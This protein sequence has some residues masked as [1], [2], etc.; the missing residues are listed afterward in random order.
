M[1]RLPSVTA[2]QVVAALKRAGYVEDRQTGSHLHLWS[3]KRRNVVTVP[4]HPGDMKRGTLFGIIKSA[5]LSPEEFAEL[6]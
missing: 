1:G 2:K 4:M 6:L 5:G 3:E